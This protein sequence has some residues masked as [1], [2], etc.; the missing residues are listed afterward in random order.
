[1]KKS[2]FIFALLLSMVLTSCSG[3]K[4]N[5]TIFDNAVVV[6]PSG[7]E[8]SLYMNRESVEDILG[9]EPEQGALPGVLDYKDVSVG[10]TDGK[11]TFVDFV[12]DD[13]KTKTGIKLGDSS[14]ALNEE[15]F[16][17][18]NEKIAGLYFSQNNEELSLMDGPDKTAE[19]FDMIYVNIIIDENGTISTI[20]IS[21]A[22]VAR[23]L[24][25]DK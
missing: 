15:D 10:F 25:L 8:L 9:S 7:E 2:F 23:T 18:H 5:L 4:E 17:F 13:S 12:S 22:N 16:I 1:M 3:D 20:N 11:L 6:L 24:K 14:S 19:L 21:D